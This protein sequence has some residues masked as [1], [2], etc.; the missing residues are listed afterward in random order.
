MVIMVDR[1]WNPS[2]DRVANRMTSDRPEPSLRIGIGHDRHR[3]GP[4]RRL[5][6]GGVEVPHILG[7]VGHSDADVVLHA[8]IDAILGAL[9]E[10][11]IGEWFPDDAAENKDRDSR[12]MLREVLARAGGGRF[13]LVNVDCTILAE[14]PKLA[15]YKRA[16]QASIAGIVGLPPA[17][18]GV[19][20][21]TG[22][23]VGPVGRE[24]SV[25]AEVAVLLE[26]LS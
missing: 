25:D 11:D 23:K 20:A 15:D 4:G 7:L 5:V 16:I 24:E 19:K 2:W 21:K 22:E 12:D 17:R 1:R 9:G 8:L 6:L 14:R 3:L 13:R 18:V 10:G 26:V